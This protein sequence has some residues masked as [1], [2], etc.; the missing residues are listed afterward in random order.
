MEN[1][2]KSQKGSEFVQWFGPLLDALKELGGSAKPRI[3]TDLVA[4][5]LKVPISVLE[6]KTKTGVPRFYNQV[7]W[8]RQYLVN[9]GFI[10]GSIRGTWTLT[11]KGKKL[12]LS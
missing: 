4:K 7:A 12:K 9:A 2:T 11:D 6:E 5:N 3:A 8:A 10:D 1:N